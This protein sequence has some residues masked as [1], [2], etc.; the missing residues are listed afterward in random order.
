MSIYDLIIFSV[1]AIFAYSVWQHNNISLLARAA[2]KRYC[3]KEGIQLLDQNV[4][5]K[6]VGIVRSHRS[7]FAIK[8]EY[9]FEFSS[10]GDY[11]AFFCDLYFLNTNNIRFFFLDPFQKTFYSRF[12]W[13]PQQ[14]QIGR[15]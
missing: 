9:V 2:T 15:R 7:L 6:R 5:L 10:V 8:R 11:Q 12:V 3:E 1:I 13:N 4:I 14:T